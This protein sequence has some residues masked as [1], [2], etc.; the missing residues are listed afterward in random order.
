MLLSHTTG[1]RR[2]SGTVEVAH[3]MTALVRIVSMDPALWMVYLCISFRSDDS[4]RAS[5]Y[6]DYCQLCAP[7]QRVTFLSFHMFH[8]YRSR[9]VLSYG[10]GP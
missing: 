2:Q 4:V 6:R 1:A 3:M 5:S 7:L 9:D 10:A 8:W